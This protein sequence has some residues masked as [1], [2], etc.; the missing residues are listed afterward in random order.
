[1]A[2]HRICT[3]FSFPAFYRRRQMHSEMIL[4]MMTRKRRPARDIFNRIRNG[5]NFLMFRNMCL[6]LAD[7]ASY[8]CILKLKKRDYG[9]EKLRRRLHVADYGR[10][11]VERSFRRI[12]VERAAA[13]KVSGQGGLGRGVGEQHHALDGVDVGEIPQQTRLE[14]SFAQRT[15]KHSDC[16]D[17]R[18]LQGSLGLER[19]LAQLRRRN[20]LQPDRL[21]HRPLGLAGVDRPLRL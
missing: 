5:N 3:K 13:R 2:Q 16:R 20:D 15:P 4:S 10:C 18:A 11:S 21:I 19:A 7:V 1:M 12:C 6:D 17:V 8:L 14:G 9:N